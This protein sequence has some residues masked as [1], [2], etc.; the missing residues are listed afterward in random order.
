MT[1]ETLVLIPSRLSATRLP[2]KPLALIGGKPMIVQV[3][4]RALEAAIG[5]VVVACDSPEIRD[6]IEAAGGRAVLTDPALPSGTDRIAAA[7][8]EV[9]RERR[10][11]RIVNLQGDIPTVDPA[12]VAAAAAALGREDADIGT[13]VTPTTSDEERLNPNV[14]KAVGTPIADRQYRALYFSRSPVPYGD[15]DCFHHIGIYSF[16]RDSLERFVTL[17]P[18]PLEQREKLEQL[19]ALENGMRIDFSVVD[20]VPLGVDTP[21]DLA[22][23]NRFFDDLAAEAH[24]TD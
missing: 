8:Q 14:V 4:L 20:T 22:A 9:D 6:V 3:Y 23:A 1:S 19:R 13:V 2:N 10:F 24:L 11:Q 18:S 17:P 12:T 7:L 15:G 16:R 21:A 5:E